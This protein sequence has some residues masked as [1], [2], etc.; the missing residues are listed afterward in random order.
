MMFHLLSLSI[1][2]FQ[3]SQTIPKTASQSHSSHDRIYGSPLLESQKTT[4]QEKPLKKRTSPNNVDYF[5]VVC[6]WFLGSN[7]G[8]IFH[9]HLSRGK[10]PEKPWSFLSVK[11]QRMR[12]ANTGIDVTFWSIGYAATVACPSR[13]PPAFLGMG[14]GGCWLE[15]S[16]CCWWLLLYRCKIIGVNNFSTREGLQPTM[17]FVVGQHEISLNLTSAGWNSEVVVQP[18]LNLLKRFSLVW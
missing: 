14:C 9:H 5:L 2:R 6:E 3:S 12:M 10:T 7:H 17:E 15:K 18:W 1:C 11:L 4:P 16:S 13:D 8:P